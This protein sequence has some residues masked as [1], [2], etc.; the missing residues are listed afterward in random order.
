MN[1]RP[2]QRLSDVCHW[3]DK[4]QSWPELL[5]WRG[6]GVAG[7]PPSA[8]CASSIFWHDGFN[9]GQ[10]R[11]TTSA[12]ICSLQHRWPRAWSRAEEIENLKCDLMD[13]IK[14]R[15]S[16]S[17]QYVR[18][19]ITSD[20]SSGA[21]ASQDGGIKIFPEKCHISVLFHGLMDKAISVVFSTEVCPPNVV[22]FRGFCRE[23]MRTRMAIFQC[24]Y[25]SGIKKRY[26]KTLT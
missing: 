16:A 25:K 1:A 14:L 10:E 5:C 20:G 7:T 19:V 23:S 13:L 22:Y 4:A 6:E 26:L 12:T 17:R 24:F 21:F 2:A 9:K 8:D 3:P 15:R 11:E 18:E